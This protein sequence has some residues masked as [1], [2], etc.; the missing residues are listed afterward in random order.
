VFATFGSSTLRFLLIACSR[1]LEPPL[2]AMN[3]GNLVWIR[4]PS[5]TSDVV[6]A[7]RRRGV[8]AARHRDGS[9]RHV[10]AWRCEDFPPRPRSPPRPFFCARH[11]ESLPQRKSSL[12]RGGIA[13]QG[14]YLGV[15]HLRHG[16]F[17]QISFRGRDVCLGGASR[18][19]SSAS[20]ISLSRFV[21]ASAER[22]RSRD[23]AGRP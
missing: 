13:S 18:A 2:L 6:D 12:K 5:G 16:Q 11:V 17:G 7:L 15:G 10:L 1:S 19:A 14:L 3:A 4:S 9:P 20:D 23:C 22:R 8:M 21:I